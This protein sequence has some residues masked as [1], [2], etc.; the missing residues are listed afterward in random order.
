MDSVC[1]DF[2]SLLFL[3]V[4]FFFYTHVTFCGVHCSTAAF[5]HL[6]FTSHD[7]RSLSYFRLIWLWLFWSW[8][9]F[10]SL[11]RQQE[12]FK[13][14]LPIACGG[15]RGN[16]SLQEAI[17]S[18]NTSF[19]LV[20]GA[21][22]SIFDSFGCDSLWLTSKV[23]Q[24]ILISLP[25]VLVF[26]IYYSYLKKALMQAMLHNMALLSQDLGSS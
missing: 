5:E 24:T 6:S 11:L 18:H 10:L 19:P 7:S 3:H 2:L 21:S 12:N 26:F 14:Q 23:L 1:K 16:Q 15:E 9:H 22:L 17:C 8:P 25:V 20:L 4:E 13:A